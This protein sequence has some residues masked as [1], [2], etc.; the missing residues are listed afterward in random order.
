MIIITKYEEINKIENEEVRNYIKKQYENVY[1]CGADTYF[2][3]TKIED[4][5]FNNIGIGN[6]I[7]IDNENDF[8]K[9]ELFFDSYDKPSL[10]NLILRY[11]EYNFEWVKPVKLGDVEL[12]DMMYLYDDVE[13]TNYFINLNGF[14]NNFKELINKVVE[15]Y[16][17][18]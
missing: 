8:I 14:N 9:L 17:E 13:G 18:N 15:S 6:M 3:N 11:T 4:I 16:K 10:K 12:I 7:Y 5:D 1:T 2:A